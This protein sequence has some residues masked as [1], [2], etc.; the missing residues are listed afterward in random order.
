MLKQKTRLEPLLIVLGVALVLGTGAVAVFGGAG[1]DSGGS[2]ESAA[3]GEP[4]DEIVIDDFDYIPTE[5]TV[6]AGAEITFVNDDTVVHTATSGDAPS[7]DGTF[8]T[9]A[10]EEGGATGTVTVEEP[11][12]YA[13]FCDFHPTMEATLKV[14][15]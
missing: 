2:S 4:V 10:I 6:E 3:T 11:G 8:N 13:Y 9:S 15:E 12:T 5:A 7:S 14:V 1:S